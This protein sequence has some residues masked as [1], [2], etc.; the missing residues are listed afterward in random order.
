MESATM[1]VWWV[2]LKGGMEPRL[3]HNRGSSY[4]ET[5]CFAL[6]QVA[7]SFEYAACFWGHAEEVMLRWPWSSV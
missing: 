5:P 6:M 2:K 3:L 7:H 4:A 1:V